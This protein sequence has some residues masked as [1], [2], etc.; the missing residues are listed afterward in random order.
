ME[1]RDAELSPRQGPPAGR[2]TADLWRPFARA[3]AFTRQPWW[4]RL[5]QRPAGTLAYAALLRLPRWAPFALQAQASTFF[6]AQ[7]RVVLP[8][9]SA[10]QLLYYGAIEEDVTSFLLTHVTEG[11]TFIDAGANLGYF[12]LLAAY[13]VRASGQVHAFE[14]AQRTCAILRDNTRR[15]PSITVQQQALWSCRTRLPFH[16]YRPRYG[17]LNSMRTHRLARESAL[18]PARSYHVECISLDEYCTAFALAPDFIKID[19][20]TAEPEIIA[21]SMHMLARHRPTIALEVWDDAARNSRDDV[22]FLMNQGYAVFE[23]DAG[24]ITP[25]R[26]RDRY[27]YMNLLFIHPQRASGSGPKPCSR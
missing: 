27:E 1:R 5:L 25:H 26:L 15:Y 12:S 19:A 20:E 13:L 8:E 14:P 21:G 18:T 22:I 10:C 17:A 24:A 16:E 23:Y 4:R 11:M 9:E 6:G 7:L 2:V 3:V